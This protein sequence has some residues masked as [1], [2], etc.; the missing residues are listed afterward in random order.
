MAGGG[1]AA[2]RPRH[3]PHGVTRPGAQRGARVRPR[4]TDPWVPLPADPVAAR[5]RGTRRAVGIAARAADA[6]GGASASRLAA[7]GVTGPVSDGPLPPVAV[8]T[9]VLA[10]LPLAHAMLPLPTARMRAQRPQSGGPE[11]PQVPQGPHA[12]PG[13]R[14]AAGRTLP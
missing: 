1:A 3:A 8:T 9:I 7:R 13:F 12:L 6:S 10:L 2:T 14:G 4:A 11:V 5:R